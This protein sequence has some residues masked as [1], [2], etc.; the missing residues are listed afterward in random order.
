MSK[1]SHDDAATLDAELSELRSAYARELPEKV[2][3]LSAAVARAQSSSGD[4]SVI[5][6]AARQ[7]H[8]LRGTAGSYGYETV[9]QLAAEIEEGL[10]AAA[11]DETILTALHALES[12]VAAALPGHSER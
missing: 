5:K 11:T 6:D 3:S 7:A 2:Q 1:P 10:L 12:A 9:S 8:R 4:R